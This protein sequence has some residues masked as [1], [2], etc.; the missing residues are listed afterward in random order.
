M[1]F[2]RTGAI[3]LFFAILAGALW[4][5]WAAIYVLFA[6]VATSIVD[7]LKISR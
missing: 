3:I 2:D 1:H 7:N 6:C 4:G 5:A